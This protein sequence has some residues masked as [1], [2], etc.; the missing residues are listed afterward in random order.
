MRHARGAI[1]Y[2]AEMKNLCSLV[3]LAFLLAAGCEKSGPKTSGS[4][5]ANETALLA[6]LPP[7]NTA[8][9]GGNYLRFQKHL[10]DSAMSKLM[11]ALN[12]S[13][14]GISEWTNCFVD[15]KAVTMLGSVKLDGRAVAM[16]FVMNGMDVAYIEG[17]A[18]RASFAT[19]V[20]P[21]RKF[22]AIDMPHPAGTMRTGYLVLPSGLLYTRQAISLVDATGLP[23]AVDRASL[24]AEIAALANGTAA[25]D[26]ALVAAMSSVDR[27]RAMWF[28]GSGA[29]TPIA[30]KLGLVAGTMDIERGLSID[31]TAQIVDADLADQIEKGVPEA[32]KQG[33]L[34]GDSVKAVLDQLTFS[35]AGDR[36]RFALTIDNAQLEA[37]MAK[38]A[39]MMGAG[40]GP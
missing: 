33:A 10:Q 20:D 36:L 11:S 27:S 8:L 31:V 15:A 25:E 7:G 22:I 40:T 34:L 12:N 13:S 23:A 14:P 1:W 24:E 26:T 18:K 21:D 30:D 5:A 38:L 28:V 16:R 19:T 2:I 9:I 6:S 32:R 35:R 39:P 37:L 29:G 3:V 4:L 17:C